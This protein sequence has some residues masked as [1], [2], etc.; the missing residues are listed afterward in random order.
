[1]LGALAWGVLALGGLGQALLTTAVA[2]DLDLLGRLVLGAGGAALGLAVPLG[3]LAGVAAGAR[4]L[5][6]EGAWLGLRSMGVGGRALIGPVGGG[7]LVVTAA[8]LGVTH[9]AEPA[10]RAAL[11]EARVDAAVRV[12]PVEGRTVRLG[13]WSAAVEDGRLRFAGEGWLGEA[14]AWEVRPAAAG[15]VV[16][17][18]EGEVRSTDGATRARFA[19][20]EAPVP[21]VGTTGKVHASERT[22]PELR[23]QVAISAA[24]GRDAYERWIL[25]KRSVLPA[26]LVPLGLGVLPFA[27]R[28]RGP[29][30][31]LVGAQALTVWGVVRIADQSVQSIGPAAASVATLAAA[32]GWLFAGWWGWRDA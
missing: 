16:A 25:W 22:T 4:K 15:V 28:R 27:L 19:S 18:H 20:L 17:L 29:V 7:L 10:A 1:M 11:R 30:A 9:Y 32:L 14:A 24:L 13:P 12:A 26:C 8:W 23:A 2:P 3:G 31:A 21:L 6:E 5:A